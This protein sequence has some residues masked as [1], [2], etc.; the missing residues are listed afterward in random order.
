MRAW[1]VSA[2]VYLEHVGVMVALGLRQDK[3]SVLFFCFLFA[4]LFPDLIGINKGLLCRKLE[5]D[6]LRPYLP[7]VVYSQPTKQKP[8]F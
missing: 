3:G 5:P 6:F 7:L 8:L 1:A 4:C 2:G